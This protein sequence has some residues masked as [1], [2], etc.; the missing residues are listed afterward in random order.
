[1]GPIESL[2]IFMNPKLHPSTDLAA[3]ILG[4][5]IKASKVSTFDANGWRSVYNAISPA[6]LA[7]LKRDARHVFDHIRAKAGLEPIK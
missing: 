1:M 2:A 7:R 5:A 6:K 4:E 3:G